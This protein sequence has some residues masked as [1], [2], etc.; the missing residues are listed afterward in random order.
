MASSSI[1]FS[2]PPR[3]MVRLGSSWEQAVNNNRKII[4]KS[5]FVF[6]PFYYIQRL[7]DPSFIE[8]IKPLEVDVAPL[9]PSG[10]I[11]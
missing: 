8:L 10:L 4:I 1:S 9:T 11:F 6:L 2:C 7:A 3:S 5:F